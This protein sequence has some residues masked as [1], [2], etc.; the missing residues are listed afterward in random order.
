MSNPIKRIQTTVGQNNE[1]LLLG[2]Y[3][4]IMLAIALPLSEILRTGWNRGNVVR[5]LFGLRRYVAVSLAEVSV[6]CLG[7]FIGLLLLMLIDRKKR[8]QGVLLLVGTVVGLIGMAQSNFLIDNVGAGTI[9]PMAFGLVG[10]I[11]FGGGRKFLNYET[12]NKLE[13]R[14]ASK[15]IYYILSFIVVFALLEAHIQY[16]RIF[17]V[18]GDGVVIRRSVEMTFGV[19]SDGLVANLLISGVF[20]VSLRRFVQYDAEKTLFLLGPPGSGKSMFMISCYLAARDS[21][22]QGGDMAPLEPTEELMS[23]V[24]GLDDRSRAWPVDATSVETEADL[25]MTYVQGS[26]FPKNLRL[27]TVD[28][29]GEQLRQLPDAIDDLGTDREDEHGLTTRRLAE[30][31]KA[32]DTLVFVID[33]ERFISGES[34]DASEYFTVLQQTSAVKTMLVA[35]KAD[36]LGEQFREQEKLEFHRDYD[37][38]KRFV[39]RELRSNEQVKALMAESTASQIY[40]VGVQTTENENG[41]TVPLISDRGGLETYGY[42]EFLEAMD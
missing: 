22:N 17:R 26:V 21:H 7:L 4:V 36:L 27:E 25:G 13:F 10:G 42:K 8:I 19:I 30:R 14:R 33:V 32:A 35:T 12:I 6:F 9:G 29:A 18:L 15:G 1:K 20:I 37:E 16:P 39:N 34:M 5:A 31:V 28:Y 40:P 38:F 24:G 41:E 3:F 11:G 2:A 23:M